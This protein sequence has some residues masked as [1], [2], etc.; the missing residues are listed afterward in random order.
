MSFPSIAGFISLNAMSAK[1]KQEVIGLLLLLLA[2]LFGVS[3][4]ANSPGDED[5]FL[6]ESGISIFDWHPENEAGIAGMF[7]SHYAFHFLGFMCFLAPIALLM[8]GLRLL[9]KW[10]NRSIM[11]RFWLAIGAIFC[12]AMIYA[13]IRMQPPIT[14]ISFGNTPGGLMSALV[15][16]LIMRVFGSIG[17]ILVCGVG[18]IILLTLLIDWRPSNWE[19]RIRKLPGRV[20]MK[21]KGISAPSL[22]ARRRRSSAKV[23]ATKPSVF[24]RITGVFDFDFLRPQFGNRENKEESEPSEATTVDHRDDMPVNETPDN[25]VTDY[26]RIAEDV[27]KRESQKGASSTSE[28]TSEQCQRKLVITRSQTESS[29]GTCAFPDIDLLNDNPQPSH[30]VSASELQQMSEELLKTLKTFGVEVEGGKIETY[31]GPVIT[32]YDFKPGVGVKVNQIVNLADD[33]ALAL[34]ARRIRILAPV[35]G[36]AAV[37][38]EIPNRHPQ[39]VY[40]KDILVSKEYTSPPSL[41]PLALGRT[42]SGQP[43]VTDLA[44][45][46]HLLVAGATG[47]GKSVC[48]NAIVT[49]LIYRHGPGTLRFLFID[50]KMLELSVYQGLP[51]L[52]RPVVTTARKAETLL[53]D[54]VGEMENRYRRLAAQNVRNI[55]DYNARAGADEKLPYIVIMVDELADLMMSN[56]ST[57]TETLITRLAQMARAVGIHLILSTQRPSVDVITGL[58]KANFPAR[59]AFQVATRVDSRTI[60]DGNGAEKLLGKGDLLFLQ[61]GQPEPLRIHGALITS[62][63]TSRLMDFMR[64]Q[65]VEIPRIDNFDEEQSAKREADFGSD[66]LLREAAEVVVRHK[67]GSVSLLQR[68]LG[69][70]YQRAARLID[71]LEEKKIVGIYDGSKAREVLVDEVHL[72]QML[73]NL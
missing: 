53:N 31:P 9:V 51:H 62:E 21:L 44:A 41:L 39:T 23:K 32:R 26:A 70:G 52:E 55:V 2:V 30:S 13:V 64:V 66:P 58:I 29:D 6:P 72:Q 57:R 63:E 35:P 3:L 37:G 50:P 11:K 10:D 1:R 19:E 73:K 45:M 36:K 14:E 56:T 18:C 59:I 7:F 25:F 15:G 46:P 71:Q 16:S 61:P 49:S 38:V 68:R 5:Y 22:P 27:L 69:V 4:L 48:L 8:Y 28:A 43:Y 20:G 67:Q 60:L 33:L 65:K 34:R 40:L 12:C 42:T 47:S 17:A 24:K 54:A